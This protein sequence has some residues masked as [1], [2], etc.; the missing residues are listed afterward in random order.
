MIYFPSLVLILLKS[1]SAALVRNGL[2]DQMKISPYHHNHRVES[3]LSSASANKFAQLEPTSSSK[4][5]DSLEAFTSP[6]L[7]LSAPRRFL[8]LLLYFGNLI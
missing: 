8:F 5:S 3:L 4:D 7:I 6:G 1:L 2:I